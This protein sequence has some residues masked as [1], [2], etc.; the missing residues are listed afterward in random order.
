M[1]LLMKLVGWLL[2]LILASIFFGVF[3]L[4]WWVNIHVALKISLSA[5]WMVIIIFMIFVGLQKDYGE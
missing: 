1:N 2:I 3:Y 4:I 5:I